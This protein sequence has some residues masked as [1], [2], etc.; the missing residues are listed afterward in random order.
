M[1]FSIFIPS[2]ETSKKDTPVEILWT[3]ILRI[4]FCSC[5]FLFVLL[6][7]VC[8]FSPQNHLLWTLTFQGLGFKLDAI[9]GVSLK[10]MRWVLAKIW[11]LK[12]LPI[13]TQ[14]LSKIGVTGQLTDKQTNKEKT[15]IMLNNS[16]SVCFGPISH[17]VELSEQITNI[18]QRILQYLITPVMMKL[19]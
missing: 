16:V 6:F 19:W 10:E 11:S 3:W 18:F 15:T 13:G 5:L 8:F 17:F 2:G 1:T 14:Y 7:D 9:C 4:C 12:P